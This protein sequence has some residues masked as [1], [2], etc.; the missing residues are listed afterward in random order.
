[1]ACPGA[2]LV[3]C[4]DTD[5]ARAR[6]KAAMAGCKWHT[7]YRAVIDDV[8]AVD[9]CT[10]PHA[11]AEIAVEA[12]RRGK[13][14]LTEKIIARTIPEAQWMVE[15]AEKAGV[16]LM[17]AFVTRYWPEY[18]LVHDICANGDIGDP[19]QALIQTQSNMLPFVQKQ[20]WRH[21]PYLFPMGG[22]LSHGC[23]YLDQLQWTVGR[24]AEAVSLSHAKTLGK[25]IPGGDDTN[26]AVFRHENG[27]VSAYLE[28]WA[29]PFGFI[30][31]RFEIAGTKASVRMRSDKGHVYVEL[32]N[33]DGVKLLGDFNKKIDG[34]GGHRMHA[35]MEYFVNC[36]RN[37]TKPLTDGREGIKPLRVILAA[38]AGERE[39]RIIN[40]D[41]FAR[42]AENTAPWSEKAYREMIEKKYGFNL[43]DK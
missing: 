14:I 7:D 39:G 25:V 43:K 6:E 23:H 28:S 40:V 26:C 4:V 12:A 36:V 11:H 10:P 34:Q 42:R 8:E 30:G 27:A 2:E 24:I 16:I 17:V 29:I 5:E 9:I 13:H 31:A 41:E 35:Q 19:L 22:F 20:K 37:N 15:E 33:G 3:H 18:R 21:D 1:L 32:I 38:E